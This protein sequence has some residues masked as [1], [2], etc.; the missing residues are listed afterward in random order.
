MAVGSD[1]FGR[2]DDATARYSAALR[3]SSRVRLLRRA[4]PVGAVVVVAAVAFVAFVEPFRTLPAGLTVGPVSMNGTKVTM[5]LP[6]LSG[7]KKDARPYEVT[8]RW[9]AQ[10]IKNPTII[11]LKDIRA[12]IALQERGMATVEAADGI[13]NTQSEQIRLKDDVKITSDSGYEARLSSATVEFKAGTVT[14]DDPVTV[15]FT[16]GTIDAE[17]V[18]M[19][20][21]GQHV[22]F[23]GRV[24]TV[25]NPDAR[26]V[27]AAAGLPPATT[28]APK[29]SP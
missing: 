1:R 10:D 15:R 13:Y 8:A 28:P 2:D 22:V 26:P 25:M 9:A 3:H 7:F 18:D 14:S 21:N 4:I 27:P 19:L 17:G 6:K 23:R 29:V 20:D 16:G 24:R 12:R 11:E 5:E